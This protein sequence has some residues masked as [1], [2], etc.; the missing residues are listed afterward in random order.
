MYHRVLNYSALNLSS[1][2]CM[3]CTLYCTGHYHMVCWPV[4]VLGAFIFTVWYSERNKTEAIS[5]PCCTTLCCTLELFVAQRC[6]IENSSIRLKK[7]KVLWHCSR[8][9]TCTPKFQ[10]RSLWV[11]QVVKVLICPCF[12]S[13]NLHCMLQGK[14]L[15]CRQHTS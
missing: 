6:N 9:V 5:L 4:T 1:L 12:Q 3:F 14:A 2:H 7:Q 8:M 11:F 10:F 13:F 15:R